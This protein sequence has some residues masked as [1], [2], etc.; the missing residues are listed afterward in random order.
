MTNKDEVDYE[1]TQKDQSFKGTEVS[2]KL[3]AKIVVDI[4]QK[5]SNSA[6]HQS[7]LTSQIQ[8]ETSL[9]SCKLLS[10]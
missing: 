9:A 4:A 1:V 5:T 2:R 6:K 8:M 10:K 3:I 7:V